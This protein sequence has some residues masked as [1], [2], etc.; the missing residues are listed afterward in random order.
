M[1]EDKHK[2]IEL[3]VAITDNVIFVDHSK[4]SNKGKMYDFD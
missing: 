1:C 2:F 3:D 4:V